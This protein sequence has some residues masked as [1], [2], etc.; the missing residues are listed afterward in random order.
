[1]SNL[2]NIMESA[3]KATIED[4]Y[5]AKYVNQAYNN[6]N[7]KQAKQ[8]HWAL[9][10][11]AEFGGLLF[12][13]NYN[14][15]N[16]D[17]DLDAAGRTT[18]EAAMRLVDQHIRRVKAE[19][20]EYQ[21]HYTIRLHRGDGQLLGVFD[22]NSEL[23]D[24]YY[25]EQLN[26]VQID[27]RNTD[28]AA[29]EVHQSDPEWYKE[30]IPFTKEVD[31]GVNNG[32]NNNNVFMRF[33]DKETN[34]AF[35]TLEFDILTLHK[36]DEIDDELENGFQTV[37]GKFLKIVY[38]SI[39]SK[40]QGK[41]IGGAVYKWLLNNKKKGKAAKY[42]FDGMISDKSLT[43]KKGKGSYFLWEKLI[44]TRNGFVVHWSYF[45]SDTVLAIKPIKKL[46]DW[47]GKLKDDYN[48]RYAIIL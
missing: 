35:G 3:Y 2:R 31:L 46:D 24:I 12:I 28:N 17:Y 29:Q 21:K 27:N 20:E 5:D 9:D 22:I 36:D 11:K 37:S 26:E 7:T 6:G 25:N 34:E 45:E 39:H 40:Y 16:D 30:I 41:G 8:I 10:N 4:S 13:A 14:N 15:G 18:L 38:I 44:N 23:H 42:N 1:M 48:Y 33:I 19:P 47:V 32:S 43:K